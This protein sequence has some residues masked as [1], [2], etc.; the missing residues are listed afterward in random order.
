MASHTH[1]PPFFHIRR[2]PPS[3]AAASYSYTPSLDAIL[4]SQ[5]ERCRQAKILRTD[6]LAP[7][8][9][10]RSIPGK[11]GLIAEHEPSLFARKRPATISQRVPIDEPLDPEK[12]NFNKITNNEVLAIIIVDDGEDPVEGDE[13]CKEQQQQH[14]I[15]A[16]VS[17]FMYGHSLVIPWSEHC[18]PQQLTPPAVDL[19]VICSKIAL[20]VSA[21]SVSTASEPFPASTTC[22]CTS[23]TL[24]N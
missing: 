14:R 23:C 3:Q 1:T 22:I 5:F 4:K 17:P 19:A 24:R 11:L 7:D 9:L 18:L 20:I 10:R 21:R 12:F 8:V 2:S 15:L 6:P 13:S 16:N